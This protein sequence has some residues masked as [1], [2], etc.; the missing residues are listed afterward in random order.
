MRGISELRNDLIA[1]GVLVL[2]GATYRFTQD[3]VFGAPSAASDIVLGGSTNGRML[4]KDSKGRTLKELQAI[5][6]GM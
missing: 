5:E 6:A 2:D 4:W 1:N 3:Y